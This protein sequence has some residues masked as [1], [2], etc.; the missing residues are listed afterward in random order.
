MA[1]MTW[2]QQMSV[3]VPAL[4]SDHRALLKLLALLDEIRDTPKFD[5]HF[6]AIVESLVAYSRYH[7]AREEQVMDACGFGEI[8]VH[9]AEH[10][11]FAGYVAS[12]R[13]RR[14]N[15][16]GRAAQVGELLDY[17]TDWLRHHILIQDMAFKPFVMG[18][19]LAESIARK[20]GP[21]IPEIRI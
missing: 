4:D 11:A 15:G 19:D 8:D 20:V 21:N 17:L 14:R 12:L 6:D 18:R 5:R 10:A 2:S 7:F 13:Q 3:G 1:G 16:G 9:R